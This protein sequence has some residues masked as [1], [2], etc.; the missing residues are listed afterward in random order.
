MSDKCSHTCHFPTFYNKRNTTN[1]TNCYL[2]F[3]SIC[4]CYCFPRY[5]PTKSI[6]TNKPKNKKDTNILKQE[7]PK[8]SKKARVAAQKK[9]KESPSYL[10][11]RP[12]SKEDFLK[13]SKQTQEYTDGPF[14]SVHPSDEDL[15]STESE[16]ISPPSSP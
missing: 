13:I 10:T 12:A 16:T 5:I 11:N 7:R 1:Q 4:L 3:Y 6:P 8:V 2:H 9:I 15:M 14:L